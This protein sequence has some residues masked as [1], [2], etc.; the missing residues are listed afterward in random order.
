MSLRESSLET[1]DDDEVYDSWSIST[2]KITINLENYHKNCLCV[3][4]KGRKL[5]DRNKKKNRKKLFTLT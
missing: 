3:F 4:Y 1:D 2:K 5:E